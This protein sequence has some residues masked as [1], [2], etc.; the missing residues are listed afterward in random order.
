[1][2]EKTWYYVYILSCGDGSLYTGSTDDITRRLAVHN[3][4]KGAKYTRHRLPVTL[5]YQE[6]FASKSDALKREA[7]IKK[8]KRCQKLVLCQTPSRKGMNDFD[9]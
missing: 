9:S 2:A 1:M 8:L 4:G 3:S 5:A 7:A 6:C